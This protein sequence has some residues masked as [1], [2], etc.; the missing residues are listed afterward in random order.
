MDELQRSFDRVIVDTPPGRGMPDA[1]VVAAACGQAVLVGR[2]HHTSVARLN[3]MTERIRRAGV[4]VVGVI[5]ND[6]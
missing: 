5:L 1:R 4:D 2:K 3:A 6:R